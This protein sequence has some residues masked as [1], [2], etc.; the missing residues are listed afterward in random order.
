MPIKSGTLKL[1]RIPFSIILLPVF[2][3][4]VYIGLENLVTVNLLIVFVVVH[5]VFYPASNAYNS[6][7]DNDSGSIGGLKNPPAPTKQ[8]FYVSVLLDILGLGL[9]FL[10]SNLFFLINAFLVLLSRAY[11]W[12]KVRIKKYALWSFLT[13][14]LSQGGISYLNMLGGI[15]G[16]TTFSELFSEI[17]LLEALVPSLFVGAIYP[18]TQI[19]QHQEDRENGD[20]TMSMW[21]GHKGT[22]ILSGILFISSAILLQQILLNFEFILFIS[23]MLIPIIFFIHWTFKSWKR[24]KHINYRNTMI[25]AVLSSI[26]MNIAFIFII[27]LRIM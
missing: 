3:F 18:L 9:S 2:L 11:S 27:Y 6:Y 21:V 25:M 17:H 7:M 10:V 12:R 5:F 26:A 4:A 20:F 13:V 24:E 8:L 16:I 14:S 19:Y 1:L 22:F 15:T 23:L